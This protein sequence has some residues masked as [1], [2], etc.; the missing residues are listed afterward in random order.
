MAGSFAGHLFWNAAG[1]VHW[2]ETGEASPARTEH[3]SETPLRGFSGWGAKTQVSAS[4][5]LQAGIALRVIAAAF[6]NPF[7]AAIAGAASFLV[8][9]VLI[10]AGMHPGL[11]S[12]FVRV[13]RG[14]GGRECNIASNHWRR[15]LRCR[16]SLRGRYR[17]GCR[18]G[19]RRSIGRRSALRLAEIVP[20]HRPERSAGLG[21]LILGAA[22][23]H[24][25][26]GG[27]RR[28]GEGEPSGAGQKGRY[29]EMPSHGRTFHK[30]A[31]VKSDKETV[32]QRRRQ[33]SMAARGSKALDAL[34][35][36]ECINY[37]EAAGYVPSGPGFSS[38]N[39]STCTRLP[40]MK[41]SATRRNGA[42][43][44][45]ERPMVRR[46]SKRL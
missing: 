10:E 12:R 20:R 34:S 28:M 9:L 41:A 14:D 8:G 21:R 44:T 19:F 25:Q 13:L 11:S 7:Q 15:R 3:F 39:G 16:L 23:L 17:P 38:R 5:A 22:F 29:D 30:F 32:L 43:S 6:L 35:T 4:S 27:W 40:T 36:R 45:S 2:G 1:W 24:C 31:L 26:G 46:A 37:V 42:S 18:G 33:V